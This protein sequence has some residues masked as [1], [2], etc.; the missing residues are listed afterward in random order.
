MASGRYRELLVKLDTLGVSFANDGR[1]FSCELLD[2]REM[3][4]SR[5]ARTMAQNSIMLSQ[6]TDLDV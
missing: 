4:R 5:K 1:E 6:L 2:S 3:R